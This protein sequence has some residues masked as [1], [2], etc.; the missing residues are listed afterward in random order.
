[1]GFEITEPTVERHDIELR[2]VRDGRL[3]VSYNCVRSGRTYTEG[4]HT[5]DRLPVEF[6]ALFDGGTL[7]PATLTEEEREWIE[8]EAER[9][10]FEECAL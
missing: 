10:T 4:K 3:V 8:A 9:I 1:M 2:D 5:S 7:D 6:L